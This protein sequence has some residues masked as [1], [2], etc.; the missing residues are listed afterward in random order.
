[1][2]CRHELRMGDPDQNPSARICIGSRT[3]SWTASR[4]RCAV[5]VAGDDAFEFALTYRPRLE[6]DPTQVRT[7]SDAQ[8]VE[9]TEQAL[10][11]RLPQ[12]HLRCDPVVE[13]VE[14]L[15]AVCAL[16]VAVR[17]TST[18]GLRRSRSRRYVSASAW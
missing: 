16:G 17:P 9:R 13:P 2:N 1:M 3:Q 4:I 6:P 18:F 7:V 14:D 8:V 15:F 11:E 10:V 12:P 5:V